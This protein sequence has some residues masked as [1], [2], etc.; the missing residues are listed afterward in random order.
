MP[1]ALATEAP[2]VTP[3][4]AVSRKKACDCEGRWKN[5]GDGVEKRI[6]VE[7]SDLWAKSWFDVVNA[8]YGYHRN[9]YS[10]FTNKTLIDR[11]CQTI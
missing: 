5:L 6:F 7:H 8:S 1:Y 2:K 4:T 3:F 10:H 11:G 9:C